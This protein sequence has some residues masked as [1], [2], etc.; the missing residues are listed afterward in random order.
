MSAIRIT[1]LP[2][3]DELQDRDLVNFQRLVDGV[4]TDF[5]TD[6]ATL[7]GE[8]RTFIRSVDL[9]E[10]DS[11]LIYTPDT[12]E[13]VVPLAMWMI[14]TPDAI[15]SGLGFSAQAFSG[16]SNPLNLTVD[17]SDA[18]GGSFGSVDVGQYT[19]MDQDFNLA[20]ASS[21]ANGT[22][23]IYVQYAIVPKV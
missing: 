9:S 2:V 11:A 17:P 19:D 13:L 22:G 8:V 12:D 14:Y 15:P 23:I 3:L 10:T 20:W 18:V 1:D 5:H 16:A 6:G 4:W 7:Q 21:G